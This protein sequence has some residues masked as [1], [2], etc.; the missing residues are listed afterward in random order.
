MT[1]SL[2]AQ[3]SWSSSR[4]LP[5]FSTTPQTR[6][7]CQPLALLMLHHAHTSTRSPFVPPPPHTHTHTH[8]H[9]LTLTHSYT[10]THAHT[11]ARAHTHT[12]RAVSCDSGRAWARNSNVR[13][14][15]H[16]T[17]NAAVP[18]RPRRVPHAVCDALPLAHRRLQLAPWRESPAHGVS[19]RGQQTRRHIPVRERNTPRPTPRLCTQ[20][21]KA[22]RTSRSRHG[23]DDSHAR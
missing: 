4:K 10:H 15:S 23:A 7:R 16:R 6:S 5:P 18:S 21:T 22:Q 12:H 11:R 3:H 2:G 17:R 9:S 19:R 1:L 8:T 20:R 14:H 13:R